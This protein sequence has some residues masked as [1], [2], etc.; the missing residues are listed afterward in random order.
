MV[1]GCKLKNAIAFVTLYS[2]GEAAEE[3]AVKWVL[4]LELHQDEALLVGQEDMT[5]HNRMKDELFFVAI[6]WFQV[7]AC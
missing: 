6:F 7:L 4:C 5:Y 3:S 2:L 1:L